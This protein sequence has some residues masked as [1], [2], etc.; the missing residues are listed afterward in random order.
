MPAA[1]RVMLLVSEADS[2]RLPP[3][4]TTTLHTLAAVDRAL[5]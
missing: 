4:E 2:P 1:S 3:F 5:A